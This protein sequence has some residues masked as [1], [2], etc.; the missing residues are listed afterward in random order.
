[1]KSALFIAAMLA[2]PIAI[3]EKFDIPI[4]GSTVVGELRVITP[5]AENTLLDI[6]RRF[7]LGHHEIV[8]ANPTLDIWAPKPGSRVTI[9]T[10]FILPP[11]PWKGII[12]NISQRR[13]FYF[14]PTK[15]GKVAQVITLP[16][17]IAREGWSTPLGKT[18][19]VAK[20]KDPGWFVP[21][22]IQQEKLEEGEIDFP[23]YFPPGPDN[24]MGML[25][26]QTGFKSIFIH[27]T[28]RP[29]GVGMRTS[30]GCL[31]LY[32]EDAET[33]F[34]LISA[35]VPLRVIDQPFVVGVEAGQLVMTS[36]D[37]VT[38]YDATSNHFTRAV[39]ALAPWLDSQ[40]KI[41][42][43]AYDV[44]WGTVQNLV[45]TRTVTPYFIAP[46]SIS[47]DQ[48]LAD[49]PVEPYN[50]PPYGDDANNAA[51]PSAEAIEAELNASDVKYQPPGTQ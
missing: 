29:W 11:K 26:I 6:A 18:K 32:P 16:L 39:L 12:V 4:D 48:L 7:D 8:L 20:H 14:P 23:E 38:E 10:Q 41:Y 25:A 33:L 28:N 43:S 50:F 51:P 37:P 17:S 1:M 22:S 9:P 49:M 21:K 46:F 2:Q 36:Y 31:H 30:H 34:P 47:V 44:D 27:G 24:P 15:K 3:A 13:L 45:E 19:I 35:G 40:T 42:D 5:D